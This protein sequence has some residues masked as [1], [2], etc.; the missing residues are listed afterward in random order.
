MAFSLRSALQTALPVALLGLAGA[1]TP[2]RAQVTLSVGPDRVTIANANVAPQT[3]T[4]ALSK[5]ASATWTI[6]DSTGTSYELT[7]LA[8]GGGGGGTSTG[9]SGGTGN[10]PVIIIG[11]YDTALNYLR[12]AYG[13]VI[14]R[15]SALG[16]NLIRLPNHADPISVFFNALQNDTLNGYPL[17]RYFRLLEVATK[18]VFE[19]PTYN[20]AKETRRPLMFPNDEL[21]RLQWNV[22]RAR[23]LQAMWFPVRA[24]KRVRIGVIDSG[25]GADQR[26]H[27]GLDGAD[28]R[29]VPIAPT[30]GAP[31]AHGLGLATLLAERSHE[32]SGTV[33]L[34]GAWGSTECFPA[35]PIFADERP[36][37]LVFNVGDFGPVNVFVAQAIRTA[38]KAGV[39]VVNLSLHMAVSPVVEEAIREAQAAG[40]VVVA[41]AGN[42]AVGAGARR[43]R[44][45]ANLGGVIAVGGAGE[46]MRP[47]ATSATDGVDLYAPGTDVIVGGPNGLWVYATGTSYAAPHV[48]ATV[49]MM[50]AVNP[51][52]TSADVLAALQRFAQRPFGA[53][54]PGFLNALS[55]LNAVLPPDARV[56]YPALNEGCSL[57]D[58]FGKDNDA[59][60]P[61]AYDDGIDDALFPERAAEIPSASGL[62]G[63]APNP[64]A[65]GTTVR[66][67]LAE[68]GTVHLAV[69]N[70]LGQRVALLA[71]GA[72]EAGTHA[73][74][75]DASALP[76]GVY[77]TRLT[78]ATGVFTGTMTRAK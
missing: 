30:T 54:G 18:G 55:S 72:F 20:V 51:A 29:Y 35:P 27:A 21:Y 39:D 77:F 64:F 73:A 65:D 67:A 33:G 37:V 2:A 57:A 26:A 6:S 10:T 66:F 45:P 49:A 14:T 41:S 36:E 11:G 58:A 63:A 34:L 60:T 43:V 16:V 19:Q 76:A 71:E 23:M 74:R 4:R 38:M 52:L 78:T 42:Y 56:R 44:F 40:V 1:T 46:D 22:R 25:I 50:R 70:A 53:T 59:G 8:A 62:V 47:S 32:G 48:A 13:A 12:Q 24:Q 3:L 15:D 28:V 68:A 31:L 69:Y 9:G 7:T 61:Y 5:S 17:Y 75:L